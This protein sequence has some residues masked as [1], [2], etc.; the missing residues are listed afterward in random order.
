SLA[1]AGARDAGA[2]KLPLPVI[3]DFSDHFGKPSEHGHGPARA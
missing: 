3:E 1:V 2:V